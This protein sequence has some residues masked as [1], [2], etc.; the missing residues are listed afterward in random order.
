VLTRV[1]DRIAAYEEKLRAW[2]GFTAEAARLP[3]TPEL[4][5]KI[6]NC[7]GRLQ[8]VHATYTLLHDQLIK[9]GPGQ[10]PDI[11]TMEQL[12]GVA[13]DDIGFL[14]SECQRLVAGGQ[15]AGD[16]LAGSAAKALADG[17]KAL[18]AAM[19]A[20][21]YPEVIRLYEQLPAG[22]GLQTSF[23][24]VS[25]YGQALLRTGRD[26]DASRV[27]GE[28]LQDVQ[29][30]NQVGREFQLMQLVADIQFGLEDYTN[31]FTGYVNIINRYA[32]LGENIDWARKQQAVISARNQ[33]PAE[34]K[35]FA[36]LMRA[37][38][39]FNQ[40]RDGFKVVLLAEQFLATFPESSVIPTVNRILFEARDKAEAWYV[41]HLQQIGQL[42]DEGR[43][44]EALQRLQ[45]LPV[46][47]IPPDKQAQLQ[48]LVDEMTTV[49]A[50]EAQ[51]QQ[52]AQEATL[53]EAWNKGEEYLQ[54]KAYDQAIATFNTMLETSYGDRAR[55]RISE[56]ASLAAQEDRQKAAELFVQAGAAKDQTARVD[57][58]LQSRQL[59]QD[60]L[61]KYPQ[62]D[63]GAKVRKNLVRIEQDLRA[64]DPALLNVP[65]PTTVENEDSGSAVPGPGGP[66]NM[67]E[68]QVRS[69]ESGTNPTRNGTDFSPV[70]GTRE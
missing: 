67:G 31:A 47:Q 70:P 30:Q 49:Q 57:L 17:E 5:E 18:A 32:G 35:G 54:L 15:L 3:Q 2:E 13:G 16:L 63:L 11:A 29:Q 68:L 41:A 20:G 19:T 23:E 44:A 8:A 14:E 4:S 27:L 28:L 37:Y 33:Q 64:I 24:S 10:S 9:M 34:V 26:E 59:L 62:S 40:A 55:S 21:D 1:D 36:S 12:Q 7:Q 6:A 60:I 58:L 53:Q 56:A 65:A 48:A 45:S 61:N 50:R 25:G 46:Q 38:L 22:E 51:V 66:M 52:A 39:G 43:F 42:K 69:V